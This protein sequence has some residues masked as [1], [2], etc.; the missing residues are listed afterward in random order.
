MIEK[1]ESALAPWGHAYEQLAS[2]V[3]VGARDGGSRLES[4]STLAARLG[5]AEGTLGRAIRRMT[6]EGLLTVEG[7][8][9]VV[10]PAAILPEGVLDAAQR[11]YEASIREGV[12]IRYAMLAVLG[13]RD[14]DHWDPEDRW[15]LEE[16]GRHRVD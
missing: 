12:S 15:D 4:W 5:V 9:N 1:K 8:R 16:P 7:G 2:S 6:E 13:L 10:A 3:L 11:L 14:D